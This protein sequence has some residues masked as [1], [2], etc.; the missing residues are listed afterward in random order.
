MPMFYCF[1]TRIYER[2]IL[3]TYGWKS[4][5]VWGRG[6]GVGDNMSGLV[7]VMEWTSVLVIT[8]RIPKKKQKKKKQLNKIQENKEGEPGNKRSQHNVSRFIV[9]IVLKLKQSNDSPFRLLSSFP[10]KSWSPCIIARTLYIGNWTWNL[11][12]VNLLTEQ[13]VKFPKRNRI[14]GLELHLSTIPYIT[15]QFLPFLDKSCMGTL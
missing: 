9:L 11:S 2:E 4:E 10:V 6:V 7:W 15:D 12:D 3:I 14:C 13:L 1:S 8:P 5:R